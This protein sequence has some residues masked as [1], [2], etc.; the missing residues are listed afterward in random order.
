MQR[1]AGLRAIVTGAASGIGR[2][3]AKRYV[4]E[5]ARVLGVVQ[6]EDERVGLEAEGVEV[7]VGDVAGF[8]TAHAMVEHALDLFGGLDIVVAN[9]GIW[10]FN[11][12]L[13]RYGPDRLEAAFDEIMRVNVGGPLF[14]ARAA[15]AALRASRGVMIFTGSNASFL[16]GGGGALY[17][18][19]KFA[20]RGLVMQLSREFAPDVRVNGVA[21][22]PTETPLSGPV[23]GGQD[24]QALNSDPGR[25]AAM[26]G[27]VPLQRVAAPEDH[28]DLYVVLG[29]SR[30]S[31]FVT[32][33]MFVSDG[34]L[35]VSV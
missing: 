3:V 19:S 32:G 5:G 29:S 21:P 35:T 7:V 12:K 8:N 34:G 14:A 9:A 28:A 6:R 15:A 27:A 13:E 26:A 33:A 2:A 1:L 11:R 18:A 17:T 4:G 31:G 24:G 25:V 16:A 30:E 10:D 23:S 20:V 22:G